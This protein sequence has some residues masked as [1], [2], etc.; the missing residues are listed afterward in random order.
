MYHQHFW[1]NVIK[2]TETCLPADL[3]IKKFRFYAEIDFCNHGPGACESTAACL[4]CPW[5]CGKGWRSIDKAVLCLRRWERAWTRICLSVQ[6]FLNLFVRL[7][8][9]KL[10]CPFLSLSFS[11]SHS[12]LSKVWTCNCAASKCNW[13]RSSENPGIPVGFFGNSLSL[14]QYKFVDEQMVWHLA[15]LLSAR[16]ARD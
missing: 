1:E 13:E 8:D 3:D 7:T 15:K 4:I 6:S 5:G 2:E 11:R 16:F 14:S 10:F 9:M 12:F